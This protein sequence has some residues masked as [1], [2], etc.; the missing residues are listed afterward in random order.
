VNANSGRTVDTSCVSRRSRL[1]AENLSPET[2]GGAAPEKMTREHRA[3]FQA[4]DAIEEGQG[5]AEGNGTTNDVAGRVNQRG[6]SD[7]KFLLVTTGL[8]SSLRGSPA[9]PTKGRGCGGWWR[10]DDR[11][12]PFRP[13][14]AGRDGAALKTFAWVCCSDPFGSKIATKC[15]KKSRSESAEP[16][17]EPLVHRESARSLRS[18]RQGERAP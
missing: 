14:P 10:K 3:L 6:E 5:E 13:R 2:D 15:G 7:D 16:L 1:P 8:G 18:R 4:E 12:R 17:R 9:N 11:L